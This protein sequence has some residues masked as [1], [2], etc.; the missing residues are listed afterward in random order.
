MERAAGDGAAGGRHDTRHRIAGI[1]GRIR[2]AR[3]ARGLSLDVTAGLAGRSKGWLS[4]IENGLLPLE[5]LPEIIAL[6]EALQVPMPVLTGIRCPGCP[7]KPV[8]R[9]VR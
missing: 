8:P 2:Q 6:A 1:G 7:L 9:D 5:R 3:H 4:M